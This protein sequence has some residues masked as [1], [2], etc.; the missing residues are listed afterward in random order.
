MGDIKLTAMNNLGNLPA[1][2]LKKLLEY[3]PVRD[4]L[5]LRKTCSHI[6]RASRCKSFFGK[7]QVN[8]STIE[9]EDVELYKRFCQEFASVVRF[10][11]EDCDE[12][13]FK[14]ILP[15]MEK[16]EEILVQVKDL[17]HICTNFKHIRKLMV[18]YIY[19]DE[20]NVEEINFSCLSMLLKLAELSIEGSVY[21]FQKLTLYR[22]MVEDILSNAKYLVKISFGK[23]HIEGAEMNVSLGADIDS[24]QEAISNANHIR[25]WCFNTVSVDDL[26]FQLPPNIRMLECRHTSCVSFKNSAFEKLEKLV[27]EGVKFDNERFEFPNLKELK[28]AGSLLGDGLEEKEVLCPNLQVLQ[29]DNVSHITNFKQ[30]FCDSLKVLFVTSWSGLSDEEQSWI[31]SKCG[32]LRHLFVSHDTASAQMVTIEDTII[33]NLIDNLAIGS[34]FGISSSNNF[35]SGFSHC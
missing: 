22:T 26:S 23:V 13:N 32:S 10:N 15:Y 33:H 11:L 18:K 1:I 29:L 5:N 24:L 4:I 19:A 28:I 9:E 12:N 25:K 6:C 8:L 14:L 30:L 21:Y 3:L 35:S 27:L 16:V 7:V 17:N 2:A 20:L 31:L 34:D